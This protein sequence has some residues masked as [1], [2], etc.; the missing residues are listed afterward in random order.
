MA[1]DGDNLVGEFL[2][3]PVIIN[4]G[5]V[6]NF[7]DSRLFGE[8]EGIVVVGG[9]ECG[10]A[11]RFRN[12][13][14]NK[15]IGYA[16]NIAALFA[17]DPASKNDITGDAEIGGEFEQ[18]VALF[19]IA[20][21]NEDKFGILL[22]S[23]FSGVKEMPHALLNG[24]AANGGNNSIA[25]VAEIFKIFVFVFVVVVFVGEE[26]FVEGVIS[27]VDFIKGDV[28]FFVDDALG[29]LRNSDDFVGHLKCFGLN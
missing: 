23:L 3:V 14:H 1:G 2:F 15:D 24:E 29:G 18:L 8:N 26:I 20:G 4:H 25:L 9:F 7:G 22:K 17:A 16:V 12:R 19:P 11:E 21:E 28:V 27:D 5:G 13:T 6:K 10:E